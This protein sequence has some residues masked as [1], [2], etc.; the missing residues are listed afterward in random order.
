MNSIQ[1]VRDAQQMWESKL[2]NPGREGIE[3]RIRKSRGILTILT[4]IINKVTAKHVTYS[5][6]L[7]EETMTV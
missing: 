2:N 7:R 6:N 3:L 1:D 4:N 5:R